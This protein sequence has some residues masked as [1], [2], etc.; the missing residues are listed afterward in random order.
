MGRRRPSPAARRFVER[1]TRDLRGEGLSASEAN[2][3][4]WKEA[5]ERGMRTQ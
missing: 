5:R 3:E 2:R 1:R 4:A